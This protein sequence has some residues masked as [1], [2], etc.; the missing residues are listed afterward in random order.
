MSFKGDK[1]VLNEVLTWEG[2]SV[3]RCRMSQHEYSGLWS[4]GK[5]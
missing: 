3:V 4:G 2:G 5:C 1:H